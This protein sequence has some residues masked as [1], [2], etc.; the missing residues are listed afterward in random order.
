MR[1][2]FLISLCACTS[3]EAPATFTEVFDEIFSQS[4]AFSTCHGG[5]AGAPF[6]TDSEAAYTSLVGAEST[7]K[8]GAILVI[9]GDPDNSYLVQKMEDDSGIEGDAMPPS[10]PLGTDVIERVRSWIEDGA[11]EN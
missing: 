1:H 10:S 2:F 11:Q 3:A 4:C 7:D 8:E 6:L 9:P 5:S